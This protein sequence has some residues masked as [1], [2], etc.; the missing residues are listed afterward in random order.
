MHAISMLHRLLSKN[1]PR[2]QKKRLASLCAATN[3]AVSGSV[4]ILSE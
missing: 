3:A 4:L 2:I 1:C